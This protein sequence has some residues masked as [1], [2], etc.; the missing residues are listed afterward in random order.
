MDREMMSSTE[1]SGPICQWCDKKCDNSWGDSA[2]VCD[3]CLRL[4]S[5]AGFLTEE[6][7]AGPHLDQ[8]VARR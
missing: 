4:M 8:F 5:N 2:M 3:K 1:E 6:I 7:L